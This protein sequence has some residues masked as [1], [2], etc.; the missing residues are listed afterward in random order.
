MNIKRLKQLRQENNLS[1]KD[2]AECL[3]ISAPAYSHYE[4]GFTEP[5][6]RGLI[7]LTEIFEVSADYLLGISDFRNYDEIKVLFNNLSDFDKKQIVAL[8]KRLSLLNME[9]NAINEDK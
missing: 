5:D 4:T 6:N 3:G 7:K 9:V 2:M 1:Q 8:I